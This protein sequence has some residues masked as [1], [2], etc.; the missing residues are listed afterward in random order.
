[1]AGSKLHEQQLNEIF[2]A[3]QNWDG[4]E[5]DAFDPKINQGLKAAIKGARKK[6]IPDTYVKRILQ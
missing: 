1:M 6:M 4:K 2:K 3:I 5:K